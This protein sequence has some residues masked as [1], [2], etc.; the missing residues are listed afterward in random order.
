MISRHKR[1]VL[2]VP[3]LAEKFQAFLKTKRHTPKRVALTPVSQAKRLSC[4]VQ[5]ASSPVARPLCRPVRKATQAPPAVPQPSRLFVR[6]KQVELVVRRLCSLLPHEA[7][8]RPGLNLYTRVHSRTPGTSNA[9]LYPVSRSPSKPQ[10]VTP[11]SFDDG[12]DAWE[13]S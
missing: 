9:Q 8:P 11:L 3:S 1:E 10:S 12:L 4:R 5:N 6:K 13:D 2:L 7:T